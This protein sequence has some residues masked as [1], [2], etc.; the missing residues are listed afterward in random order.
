MVLTMALLTCISHAGSTWKR[1][2]AL[3]SP[4]AL[5]LDVGVSMI[6]VP[7]GGA[8]AG[9]PDEGGGA[10]WSPAPT[11]HLSMAPENNAGTFK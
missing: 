9:R 3:L 11:A 7:V 8:S 6:S 10:A 2:D 1:S 4:A 5:G